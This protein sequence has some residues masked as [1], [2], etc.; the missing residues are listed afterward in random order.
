M[1]LASAAPRRRRARTGRSRVKD[2]ARASSVELP[3]QSP[4]SQMRSAARSSSV[5]TTSSASVAAAAR[6]QARRSVSPSAPAT[7]ASAA[8]TSPVRQW[9]A[10][11]DGR[12]DQRM[13][14]L[15]RAADQ[16]GRFRS[17]AAPAA[18]TSK[19]SFGPARHSHVRI[20]SGIGRGG[21]QRGGQQQQG[22][23]LRWQRQLRLPQV[24]LPSRA[25]P[26]GTGSGSGASPLS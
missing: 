24:D 3:V 18:L 5:A 13:P 16:T 14:E 15:D 2:A 23:C 1:A 9:G 25:R 10:V 6:C 8:W 4:R 20:A 21:Q 17:S 19:P 22:P 7:S 12:T 26:S 11:V